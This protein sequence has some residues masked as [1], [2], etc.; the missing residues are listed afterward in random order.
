[1]ICKCT[2]CNKA[3]AQ[4]IEGDKPMNDDRRKADRQYKLAWVAFSLL[5]VSYLCFMVWLIF[6]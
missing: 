3:Q 6:R 5:M 1:M 2:D 4:H